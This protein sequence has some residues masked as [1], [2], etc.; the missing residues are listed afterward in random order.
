[1]ENEVKLPTAE[2]LRKLVPTKE[3][4]FERNVTGNMQRMFEEL[5]GAANNG[6]LAH[7]MQISPNFPDDILN[8]IATRLTDLGYKVSIGEKQVT[9]SLKAKTLKID[10]G[11]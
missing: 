4:L 3:Q 1:M 11:V 5:A 10:W 7:E 8:E 2:E 6:A 9:Q